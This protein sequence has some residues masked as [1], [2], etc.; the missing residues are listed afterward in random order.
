MQR[1]LVIGPGGAGKTV[2]SRRLGEVLNLPVVHLDALYWRTGWQPTPPDEWCRLVEE[3]TSKPSWVIDGNYGG[4]LERRLIR[5]DAVVLL[6]LPRLICVARVLWRRIFYAG[7][8]RPSMAPGCPERVT[9]GFIHWIWTYGKRRRPGV[10]AR[11][12]A[13]EPEKTVVILRSAREVRDYLSSP[14]AG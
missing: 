12:K 4:T 6:D 9:W 14:G 8:S 11:L 5:A 1:I 7:R 13:A 2:F 10:L 3:V